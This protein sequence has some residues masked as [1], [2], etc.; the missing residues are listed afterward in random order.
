M[1]HIVKR[2]LRYIILSL[3]I[4]IST[5]G[6]TNNEIQQLIDRLSWESITMD[7]SYYTFTVNYSDSVVQDLIQIG[8][9]AV[10]VLFDNLTKSNKTVIIHMIL[11]KIIE[12]ENANDNLPM[13][14]I[15]QDCNNL[16]GWHNLYNGVIWE[17]YSK[18]NNSISQKEIDKA[19]FYWRKRIKGELKPEK[20]EIGKVF[21]NLQA[22]DQKKYPCRKVYDNKSGGIK[23][24]TLFELLDKNLH[25]QKFN[26]VFT[27]LG[28]D[29]TISKYDDCFFISYGADGIDFRFDK[30]S[31][32]TSI[33]I[34]SGYQG[35]LPHKLK[36]TDKK[37]IVESKIGKPYKS[38]TYS[39]CEWTW[40]KDKYLYIDYFS[41]KRIKT[42]AISKK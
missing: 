30:D 35:D 13:V 1:P 10:N 16:I 2:K 9:P 22:E 31:I 17:W 11:T 32:L 20:I 33:F 7:H 14:Y 23:T 18:S 24:E 34:E 4:P 38:G 26:E 25:Y 28:N 6:K 12:P 29:S 8:Q 5:F 41:D 15:Y 19:V 21:E 37:S 3:I 40:Y 36:Y 27:N 42:F 39:D